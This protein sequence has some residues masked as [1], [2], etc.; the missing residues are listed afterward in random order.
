VEQRIAPL[1]QEHRQAIV[2]AAPLAHL[3]ALVEDR[4]RHPV[5]GARHHRVGQAPH[6]IFDRRDPC[7]AKAPGI[8]PR[9]QV[10]GR[11]LAHADGSA[12]IGDAGRLGERLD[13][14][15]LPVGRPAIAAMAQ[16]DGIE[17]AKLGG[18]IGHPHCR[19]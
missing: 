11:S 19:T 1:E 10:I 13:E 14:L 3:F 5:D 2:I 18:R 16:R 12:G 8:R 7:V 6:G 9:A 4:R 17:I 15:D